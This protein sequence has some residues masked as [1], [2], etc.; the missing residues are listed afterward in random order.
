MKIP[1]NPPNPGFEGNPSPSLGSPWILTE[2]GFSSS[3]FGSC[4]FRGSLLGGRDQRSIPEEIPSAR[5]VFPVPE[6]GLGGPHLSGSPAGPRLQLRPLELLSRPPSGF[7][8]SAGKGWGGSQPPK[9]P[10]PPSDVLTSL[11]T[12]NPF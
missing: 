5:G 9:L 11:E 4:S 1:Q 8:S 6:G 7:S 2:G 12:P 3:F 10:E